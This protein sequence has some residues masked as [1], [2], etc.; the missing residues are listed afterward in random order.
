M[1]EGGEKMKL[2]G[3]TQGEVANLA[4]CSQAYVS[5]QL[6]G[7]RTLTQALREALKDL[8]RRLRE[9]ADEVEQKFARV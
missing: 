2:P 4:G 1:L 9:Q 3:I 8:P 5:Y 7:K 6:T